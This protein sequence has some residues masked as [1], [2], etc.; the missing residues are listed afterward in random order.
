[1]IIIGGSF[2]IDPAERDAFL[3]SRVEP[4][5]MSRAEQGNIEYCLAADPVEPGRV[6]LFERWASQAD[7]DAHMQRLRSSSPVQGPRPTRTTI[8]VFDVTGERPL[9]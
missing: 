5:R 3:A 7:L 6:I 2:E 9:G 1:V 4:M 8:T